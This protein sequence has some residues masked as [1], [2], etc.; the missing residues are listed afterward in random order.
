MLNPY[1]K[2]E[3]FPSAIKG[4]EVG[5]VGGWGV[6][7]TRPLKETSAYETAY[8]QSQMLFVFRRPKLRIH[9]WNSRKF[10]LTAVSFI[11]KVPRIH[12]DL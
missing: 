9:V 2:K 5:G 3:R 1:K 6:Y 4:R 11:L 10:E 12:L 8:P 7:A